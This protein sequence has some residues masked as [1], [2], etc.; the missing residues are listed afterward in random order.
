MKSKE[1]NRINENFSDEDSL[2][3]TG[4]KKSLASGMRT[5]ALT[6]L[7]K[8]RGIRLRIIR[9]LINK[10][11]DEFSK[12]VDIEVGSLGRI[13]R[14]NTCLSILKAHFVCNN[15]INYGLVI[16]PTWLLSGK[17][18]SIKFTKQDQVDISSTLM[19]IMKGKI[20]LDDDSLLFLLQ[21]QFFIKSYKHKNP[22][23]GFVKDIHMEPYLNKGDL[24]GGFLLNKDQ[25]YNLKGQP[26]LIFFKNN[27]NVVRKV[28]FI[29][30]DELLFISNDYMAPEIYKFD[31]IEKICKIQHQ[32]RL[33]RNDQLFV[34]E[35]EDMSKFESFLNEENIF[36]SVSDIE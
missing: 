18:S 6:F 32:Q 8:C 11:L 2:T 29:S 12:I 1:K 28:Y 24:V 25:Y 14:G 27:T 19:D 15:I 20:S 7:G 17:G 3:I 10:N 35:E 26:C 9:Q 33:L 5:E 31:D 23:I 30:N 21:S 4:L 22:L 34:L 13:E 16:S 36:Q